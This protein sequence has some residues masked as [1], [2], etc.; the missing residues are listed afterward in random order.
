MIQILNLNPSFDHTGIIKHNVNSNV[1][2]VDE[3]IPMV[4][5]KGNDVARV[6]NILG[7]NNYEVSN[8]LGGDVGNIII[9]ELK[10]EG[11]KS[12]NFAI[13]DETRINYALVNEIKNTTLMINEKGPEISYKEKEKYIKKLSEWLQAKQILVLAG[14]AP[15]GFTK[16]DIKNI[17]KIAKNKNMYIVI[18]TSKKFLKASLEMDVDVLKINKNEFLEIFKDNYKIN[19]FKDIIKIIKK[20][21]L[22]KV[23]ITLGK[24][25][26][27][28]YNNGLLLRG[29]NKKIFSNYAI[30]S[31]DSFLAGYLYGFAKNYNERET[32]RLAMACGAANTRQ[33]GPGSLKYC[34]VEDIRE[35]YIEVEE[36]KGKGEIEL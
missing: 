17:L 31:G 3:V 26:A 28:L 33:Y 1:V 7:F 4:S 10:K 21:G 29:F 8:I 16:K 11:I 23:I 34:D 6:L 27:I 25:G 35:S 22:T 18:D 19:K 24:K 12:W 9:K 36:L 5:G 15:K 20:Q 30:G 2:R 32:F 13:N 14:S